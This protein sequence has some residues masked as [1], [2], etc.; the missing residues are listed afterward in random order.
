MQLFLK[1]PLF[2]LLKVLAKAT[3]KKYQPQ[4]IAVTGS[5]G[6]TSAKEALACVLSN[7]FS[8][9]HGK[10]NYNN[11]IGLP[12]TILG[13][14]LTAGKNIFAWLAI[15]WQSIFNLLKTDKHYPKVLIL[16]MGADRPG[17]ISYL[18]N[19]A[20]PH[21]AVITAIGLSHI[22][23]FGSQAKILAE[24]ISIFKNL[25]KN[26]WAILNHDD[27]NLQTII[28][29]I[30]NNF[31]TFGTNKNSSL[32]IVDVHLTKKL[33]TIGTSFKLKFKDTEVPVFLPNV[34]GKQQASAAAAAA[35]VG[36]AM[37]L[38]LVEISQS[39]ATYKAALGRTNLIKGVKGTWIIDDTYNA[40][41]QSALAALEILR[42]FPEAG[43]RIAVFGD[44]RE[45]GSFSEEAHRQVGEMVH[46]FQVDYLFVIGEKSRDIARAA[47]DLGMS[48]DHIYHFPQTIE[49]GIFLQERLKPNDIVLIKGSR[50]SKMEQV[51]YEIMA[52][53]WD[54]DELLVAPISR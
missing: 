18:T 46:N 26:D 53:P 35:A 5:V 54:A 6:K 1:K 7:K 8:V 48:E 23:Y 45:L 39:L 15:F 44:M 43:R 32:Q 27:E 49:A 19:I 10:K 47:K 40:A 2:W 30:K 34:L 28:P 37:G 24:K 52:R 41:P 9:R 11:E 17:N 22:E 51:V 38:N 21:V 14:N 4:I 16:E 13:A 12:L 29:Q 31:Y 3:I 42:D 50:G 25:Q 36:L 33:D 20:P